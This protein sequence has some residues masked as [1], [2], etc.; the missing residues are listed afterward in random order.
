[1]NA[2]WL[3]DRPRSVR[4]YREETKYQPKCVGQCG[5]GV[6]AMTAT[7]M[8]P[9]EPTSRGA[10]ILRQ[11]SLLLAEPITRLSLEWRMIFKDD[12]VVLDCLDVRCLALSVIDFS[13]G[14]QHSGR[15]LR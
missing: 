11:R 7:P 15:A 5:S 2:G 8:T 14:A 4:A 13:W 3:P 12:P 9:S 10:L 6:S 1:M